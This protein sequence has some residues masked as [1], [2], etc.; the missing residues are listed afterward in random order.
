MSGTHFDPR[1]RRVLGMLAFLSGCTPYLLRVKGRKA[2]LYARMKCHGINR[3]DMPE[4]AELLFDRSGLLHTDS[5]RLDTKGL[6]NPGEHY[7]ME[8]DEFIVSMKIPDAPPSI[9]QELLPYADTRRPGRTMRNM[10]KR[11]NEKAMLA[12]LVWNFDTSVSPPEWLRTGRV[13][14]TYN[15]VKPE[16]LTDYSTPEKFLQMCDKFLKNQIP[17]QKE[18]EDA[19]RQ[20]RVDL[21]NG[22]QIIQAAETVTING[23]LWVRYA[24]NHHGTRNY[25]LLTSLWPD[26]SLLVDFRMPFYNYRANSGPSSYLEM[27]KKA[28]ANM[29]EMVSSLRVARIDGA[30]D[31]FVIDR[32]EPAPLPVRARSPTGSD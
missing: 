28:Y 14:L 26:R 29:E 11:H 16:D 12:M 20:G 21:R 30:P 6:I 9:R 5:Y 24:L 22:N 3:E 18:I 23:H 8:A 32:V 17:T 7:R 4:L 31:P 13:T 15:I 2:E 10:L 27:F 25:F 19:R 1:R